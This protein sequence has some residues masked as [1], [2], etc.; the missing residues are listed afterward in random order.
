MME[1]KQPFLI[2]SIIDGEGMID[3]NPVKK[4]ACLILP[5]GYGTIRIKGNL[6]LVTAHIGWR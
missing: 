2:V 5:D 4:G 6:S 3:E 1:Q